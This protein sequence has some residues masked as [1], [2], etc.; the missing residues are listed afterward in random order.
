MKPIIIGTDQGGSRAKL[1]LEILLKSRLI[2]QAS[3]GGGKSWLL[4]K[5]L[6]ETYGLCQQ[7][8]LD[9]ED[10]FST[11]REKFDYVL[12]GKGG[13]VAVSVRT[14][15]LMARRILELRANVIVNLYELKR[16]EREQFV[17]LFLDS[18]V[19]S[20]KELWHS[21]MVVLDE[22]HLF[23]PEKSKSESL[24]AVID[25]ETRGRK[26]G[27][28][29]IP[30]TQRLSK[31]HKD[32]AAECQNKLIGL[33][34][35]DIDR[36]RCAEELGFS[37]KKKILS[38]RDLKPGEF[39]AVGPAFAPDVNKIKV[40]RVKTTHYEAGRIS[41]KRRSVPTGK[42]NKILAKLTDLPKEAE[43]ELRDKQTMMK[44]IR[45]LERE[46]RGSK[47]RVEVK[48]KIEKVVDKKALEVAV[49]TA[50]R[51]LRT[52]IRE[53]IRVFMDRVNVRFSELKP[54]VPAAL[55]QIPAREIA[56]VIMKASKKKRALESEGFDKLRSGADQHINRCSR[57][58]L[59]FLAMREGKHFNKIQIGVMTG[60][61]SKSGG[62][63]NALSSLATSE[64]I[65]K[66]RDQIKL[67]ENVS[68][69]VQFILGD[70]YMQ[71]T[72]DALEAWLGKLGKCSRSIYAFMLKDQD[73]V[74]TKDQIGAETGY[75]PGSGGFNNSLSKLVTLGLVQRSPDGFRFNQEVLDL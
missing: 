71:P 29:L 19:S 37:E 44:R 27:F 4:R 36:K 41:K 16:H 68:L 20:P 51:E 22:A 58:I 26:R 33:A 8:V 6:E 57:A 32:V 60:Y 65:E 10:D 18:M 14:A 75:S 11:L 42:V 38:L 21:T 74:F 63:N 45:D 9:I 70:E 7:I 35:M 13:D 46:L 61:S 23:A 34:N 12:A 3:S 55:L 52:A 40:G 17:K 49:N 47:S 67:R 48:T 5:I 28:C 72:Q 24:S 30:A 69:R 56:P 64:L 15:A 62:F 43:E 53:E 54:H 2:I 31:L 39:Y 25:M 66:S 50:K 1:D 73:S 59:K